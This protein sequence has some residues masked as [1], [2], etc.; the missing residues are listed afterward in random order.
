MGKGEIRMRREIG[1]TVLSIVVLFLIFCILS[2]PNASVESVM[3]NSSSV[4]VSKGPRMDH[5]QIK[6]YENQSAEFQGLL[7]DEIDVMDS[8]L[9][10][11]QYQSVL[12]NPD[13]E[14]CPYSDLTWYEMAFNNN[15]TDLSHTQY[16]KA[17]NCTEFRQAMACLIDKDSLIAGPELAGSATRIDT[18]IPRPLFDNWVSFNV[19]KYD[20]N[21]NLLNNYPW[22]YNETHALEILWTNNW[23]SHTTYPT[24]ASL[25]AAPTP[26]RAGTIGLSDLV[27]LAKDYGKEWGN[28]AINPLP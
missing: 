14:V 23:Y 17:M 2:A 21:G 11:D 18:P 6:F 1:K 27:M 28:Y 19:S 22:D 26:A 24:L 12:G 8:P 9:T 15:V 3:S 4:A 5:L 16:R 13:I 7:N 20:S 10:N 25:L